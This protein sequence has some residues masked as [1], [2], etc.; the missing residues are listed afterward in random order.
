MAGLEDRDLRSHRHYFVSVREVW[1]NLPMA[2]AKRWPTPDHLRKWALIEE[3]YCSHAEIACKDGQAA[4]VAA[5]EFRVADQ[6]SVIKV[7][8]DVGRIWRAEPQDSRSIGKPRLQK[9]KWDVINRLATLVGVSAKD[10]MENAG[11]A[12]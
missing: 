12:A 3:G 9:S 1:L 7:D 8:A 10:I 2:V 11:Q 6:Y 4:R 5:R